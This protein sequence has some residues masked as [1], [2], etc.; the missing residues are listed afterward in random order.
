MDYQKASGHANETHLDMLKSLELS[1]DQQQQLFLYCVE[2]GIDFISTPY[3]VDSARFLVELGVKFIKT[4]SADLVD[5]L[6]HRFIATQKVPVLVATGMADFDEIAKTLE[7]YKSAKH[8]DVVLLHCVSNYPCS[9]ESIN[10]RSMATMATTFGLSV[11]YSDHSVGSHAAMA[12]VALGGVVI[13][14][15]FTLDKSLPGPDHKAS[16]TPAEFAD[17]VRN[18]RLIETLMGQGEKMMQTEEAEMSE[19]S[20]KSLA[21]KRDL[22]AGT[23][24]SHDDICLIRPNVGISPYKLDEVVGLTLARG[25][26]ELEHMRW[27][28]FLK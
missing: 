21:F 19:V 1:F 15:H 16:S 6:L 12:S 11:G 27:E 24:I 2:R 3:D 26:S 20:R 8:D 10:M 25:V 9:L 18:V 7:I 22:S 13:E 5:V 23:V 14:K 28:D 4:A 17:L